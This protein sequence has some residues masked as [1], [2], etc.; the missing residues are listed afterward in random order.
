MARHGN[1]HVPLLSLLTH[2]FDDIVK[3]LT[4]FL[5]QC[6]YNPKKDLTF[7]PIS[8]LSGHNVQNR[9]P[10]EVKT[11]ALCALLFFG[12]GGGGGAVASVS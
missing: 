3:G 6:G 8:A 10:A 5:K 7:I 2:R 9:A 11:F 1:K 12:C 4:P